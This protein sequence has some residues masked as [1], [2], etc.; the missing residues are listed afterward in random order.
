MPSLGFDKSKG[1]KPIAIVKGGQ[2]DGDVLYLNADDN[3]NEIKKDDV[4]LTKYAKYLKHLKSPERVKVMQKLNEYRRKQI[5]PDKIKENEQITELYKKI[6]DDDKK[7]TNIE[8][9]YGSHFQI[10][11]DPDPKARQVIYASGTSGSGK[12][13]FAKNFCELYLELFPERKVWLISKLQEDETLDSM[14]P[15]PK[16]LNLQSFIDDYPEDLEEFRE[17]CIIFDDYDTFTG[18][19]KKTVQKLIDDLATM[20]RHTITTMLCLSHKFSDYKNTAIILSECQYVVVY[21]FAS[22]AHSIKYML[23]THFG[24]ST[25]QI[26]DL[27]KMG[28]WVCLKKTYPQAIIS[29]EQAKLLSNDD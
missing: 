8:L 6:I 22:S 3:L 26:K 10:C 28:R 1:A 23:S 25:K 16:R 27:R 4:L 21:P 5:E 12:S 18:D 13:Y 17:S 2:N 7:L 24:L 11:P 20:G 14:N 29:A 15:K 19:A 9:P